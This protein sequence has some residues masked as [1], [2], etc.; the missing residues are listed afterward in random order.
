MT[1][2][3]GPRWTLEPCHQRL[4]QRSS[5]D[6]LL[7]SDLHQELRLKAKNSFRSRD[8]PSRLEFFTHHVKDFRCYEKI[9]GKSAS[10]AAESTSGVYCPDTV[11][12]NYLQFWLHGFL[13]GMPVV[14]N[15]D[16][17]TKIIEGYLHIS[18]RSITYKL[19]IKHGT[20]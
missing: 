13:S 17:I 12:A 11:T 18:S 1:P 6:K 8:E 5:E 10:Q 20:V 3:M 9:F 19:K 14:E 15:V 2:G 4:V 16:K 7:G